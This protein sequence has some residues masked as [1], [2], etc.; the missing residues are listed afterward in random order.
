MS[1][2][3][4]RVRAWAVHTFGIEILSNKRERGFRFCEESLELVQAVGITKE[5]VLQ[6]VDYVYGRPIGTVKE[7]V[8]GVGTTLASLCV[9]HDI[10]M[11][12]CF[13]HEL[14][15]KCWPKAEAIRA[16]HNSKVN[17]D[18]SL[19]GSKG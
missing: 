8:G 15:Y 10:D 4:D 18:S 16:K 7:E 2:F 17:K 14:D 9:T 13:N 12:G 3:Q 1:K 11:E 6:L 19:P 5:E